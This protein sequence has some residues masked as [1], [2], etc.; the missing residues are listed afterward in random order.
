MI[1]DSFTNR[2]YMKARKTFEKA[3]CRNR[4]ATIA[5][6][7]CVTYDSFHRM[8]LNKI[9]AQNDMSYQEAEARSVEFSDAFGVDI[10]TEA[11]LPDEEKYSNEAIDC[12]KEYVENRSLLTQ[13]GFSVYDVDAFCK[14]VFFNPNE[15]DMCHFRAFNSVG[16]ALSMVSVYD[17]LCGACDEVVMTIFELSGMKPM[18]ERGIRTFIRTMYK[19]VDVFEQIVNIRAERNEKIRC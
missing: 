7:L 11:F 14:M 4:Q 18:N 16:Y 9:C 10:P 6:M 13:I 2:G 1:L 19:I 12:Y 8:Q 17:Y 15:Y 5:A 3:A